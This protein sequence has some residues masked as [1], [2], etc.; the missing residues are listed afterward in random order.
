MLEDTNRF[1]WTESRIWLDLYRLVAYFY[2]SD[3]LHKLR[4][5]E[6]YEYDS[7]K[8]LR[9]MCEKAEIHELLLKIAASYRTH[10]D[11]V[12]GWDGRTGPTNVNPWH[13]ACG[14]L[15]PD[16]EKE[17]QEPLQLRDACNKILHADGLKHVYHEFRDVWNYALAPRL[18]L[19]GERNG[20]RWKA[21]L[22]IPAF[23]DCLFY[24]YGEA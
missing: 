11:S 10:Q 12:P 18:E 13:N 4:D 21:E 24:N 8:N 16:A 22:E 6:G 23:V 3:P 7:I 1:Q 2:S 9:D 19:F 20:T 17:E 15:W 5:V 14:T